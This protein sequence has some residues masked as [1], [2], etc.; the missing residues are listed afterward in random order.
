MK[1]KSRPRP[2][3]PVILLLVIVWLLF[4]MFAS[5]ARAQTLCTGVADALAGLRASYSETVL[6]EG[7]AQN[8]Q[9]LILTVNPDGT[10][11]TALTQLPGSNQVC[12]VGSGGAW[13][14]GDRAIPPLGMEG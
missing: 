3:W 14:A 9:R 2:L 13:S 5:A 7:V 4:V 11:W 10:T 1:A 6:W 12:F 8:G